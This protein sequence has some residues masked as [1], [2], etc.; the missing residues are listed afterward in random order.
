MFCPSLSYL[1][2]LDLR[3]TSVIGS[4]W[5]P[6]WSSTS[7]LRGRATASRATWTRRRCSSGSKAVASACSEKG[8][9]R[10]SERHA[11]SSSKLTCKRGFILY[12]VICIRARLIRHIYS[13]YILYY[14]IK[15]YL[16]CLVYVELRFD[17]KA[18]D[19]SERSLRGPAT[20]SAAAAPLDCPGRCGGR[21][22]RQAAAAA[23]GRGHQ[24]LCPEGQGRGERL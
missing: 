10:A 5:P 7:A 17:L 1:E 12:S 6:S 21:R 2:V 22:R 23:A 18:P 19:A 15:K 13:I 20:A 24:P 11:K 4:P 16:I 14:I 9:L 3:P 8:P